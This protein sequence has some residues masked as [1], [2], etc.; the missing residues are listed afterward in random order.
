[1]LR[2]D[3]EVVGQPAGVEPRLLGRDRD[4][5]EPLGVERLAVVRK[6]QPEVQLRGQREPEPER[7]A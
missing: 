4:G 7:R 5:R 2:R 3:D 1:M 6:D